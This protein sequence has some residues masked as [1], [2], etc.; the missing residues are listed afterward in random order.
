MP[1]PNSTKTIKFLPGLWRVLLLTTR[2]PFQPDATLSRQGLLN[3]PLTEKLN[4]GLV[5]ASNFISPIR[6]LVKPKILLETA[7]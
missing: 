5:S 2:W 6:S 1:Q 3:R 7:V 4:Y